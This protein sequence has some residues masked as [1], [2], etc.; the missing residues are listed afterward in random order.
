VSLSVCY[1][2][3]SVVGPWASARS[4]G[5]QVAEVGCPV[6]VEKIPVCPGALY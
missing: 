4:T 1:W 3:G 2:N 6:E 5:S